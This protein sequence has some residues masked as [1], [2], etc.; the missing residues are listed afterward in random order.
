[1]PKPPRQRKTDATA[2]RI[3]GR[4][5][6]AKSADRHQLELFDEPMPT[7][8]E[9]CK[10]TLVKNPPIGSQWLHEIKWDG[11][12]VSAYLKDGKAR[13]MTSGGLDWTARFPAIAA[14]VEALPARSAIIDGEAVVL[15]EAGRSHFG[16]LQVALGRHG[17]GA[18]IVLHAFDLLYYD[19]MDIRVWPLDSRRAVLEGLIGNGHGTALVLSE[20][21]D[22]PGAQIFEH[23]CKLGLEGIVSKRRG[24]PYRSGKKH[25]EWVKT[26]CVQAD[27]FVI[28]GYQPSTAMRGA[29]GA[30]HVATP[31]AD[32][33]HY[34]GSVG[35]GFSERVARDLKA[36]L[37]R[38]AS[39]TPI[40]SKLRIDKAVWC[41]PEL[42]VEIAYRAVTRDGQL[43]HASFKGLLYSELDAGLA[44]NS[45]EQ[46]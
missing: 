27:E 19:G 43:R 11:Y 31:L 12:R 16:D 1:M 29:L 25:N 7:W 13:I 18:K 3:V 37:D 42:K 20:E 41:R 45:R 9:P 39:D 35:T 2:E 36:R 22:A 28:I 8:V 33:L 21:F 4:A 46:K 5:V 17:G 34:A 10:P 32:R 15:D 40:I 44:T 23:A 26:K 30:I 6:V 24:G 14:A 38:L